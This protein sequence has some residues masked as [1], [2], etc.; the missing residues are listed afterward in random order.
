MLSLLVP[1][2]Q[3]PFVLSLLSGETSTQPHT[4]V[5]PRAYMGPHIIPTCCPPPL[6]LQHHW[7][8]AQSCLPFILS[9]PAS[10]TFLDSLGPSRILNSGS[11][12]HTQCDLC[13]LY[14]SPTSV[15]GCIST[16]NNR[17]K[18][19]QAVLHSSGSSLE[20]QVTGHPEVSLRY[21]S[22]LLMELVFHS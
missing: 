6:G 1:P 4:W 8:T 22:L 19:Q 21:R 13:G 2:T 16:T 3:G 14:R 11:E 5:L 9:P 15:V 12:Q 10:P 7:S 20:I 17:Q 18:A